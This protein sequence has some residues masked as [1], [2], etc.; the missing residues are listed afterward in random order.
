[1]LL[2]KGLQEEGRRTKTREEEQKI[3]PCK[4]STQLDEENAEAEEAAR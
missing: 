2:E 3:N 4:N 1:M